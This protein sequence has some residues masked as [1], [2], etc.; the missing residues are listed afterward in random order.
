VFWEGT[1]HRTLEGNGAFTRRERAPDD[2]SFIAYL[3]AVP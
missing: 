3:A 2:P 1:D